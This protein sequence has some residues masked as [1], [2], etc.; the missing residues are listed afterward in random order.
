MGWGNHWSGDEND[1]RE[2][3]KLFPL[4]KFL[5]YRLSEKNE[6]EFSK[7]VTLLLIDICWWSC[8]KKICVKMI[9]RIL[10]NNHRRLN[11]FQI[12]HK[13]KGTMLYMR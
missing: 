3:Q 5:K 2:F 6:N 1:L 10:M 9:S 7:L 12:N 13:K 8:H 11:E 4:A